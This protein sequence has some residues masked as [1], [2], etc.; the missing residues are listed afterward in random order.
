MKLT[1]NTPCRRTILTRASLSPTAALALLISAW[2]PP[3]FAQTPATPPVPGQLRSA[4]TVFLGMGS[5]GGST[6]LSSRL[7]M[8]F[9]QALAKAGYTLVSTPGEAELVLQAS[10]GLGEK[11]VDLL[12]F[13]PKTHALLWTVETA[14]PPA[15]RQVTYEKNMDKAAADAVGTLATVATGKLPTK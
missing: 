1:V 10:L 4:K 6:E 13:D 3:I 5:G 15:N 12:I 14:I 11:A 8:D 9:Y 7:Y 2:S